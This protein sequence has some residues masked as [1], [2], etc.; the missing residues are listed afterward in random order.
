[1]PSSNPSP[2][3]MTDATQTLSS[4]SVLKDT[5]KP[6]HERYALP[7]TGN[8]EYGFFSSRPLVPSNPMFEHKTKM[9]DVTKYVFVQSFIT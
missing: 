3:A 2:E 7:V 5:E 1:M 6:P 8:M 4:M 9:V